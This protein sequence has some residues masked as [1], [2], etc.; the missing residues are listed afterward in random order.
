MKKLLH[1]LGFLALAT[2]LAACAPAPTSA[3]GNFPNSGNNNNGT[4][5]TTNTNPDNTNPDNNPDGGTVNTM[6]SNPLNNGATYSGV[7]QSNATL[8]FTQPGVLPGL[9]S[10]ALAAL[11][12]LSTDPG[13][14]LVNFAQAAG[15]VHLDSTMRGVISSVITNKL[16]NVLP[17]NVKQALDLISD[18]TKITQTTTLQNTITV[19]TP[20]STGS[21]YVDVVV[22]G[23]A[24]DFVDLNLNPQHV[25]VKTSSA[26]LAQSKS[27][28]LG[29]LTPHPNAPVAD[30]DLTFTGGSIS[31]PIGDFINQAMGP[32][33]FKPMWGTTDLK[34]T[35]L[36]LM[37][38]PCTDLGYIVQSGVYD[39]TTLD[40]GN[41]VGT[42]IC[43]TAVT[44]A[45]NEI[46][47]EI[48]KLK[49]N[50]VKI[51]DGRATLTDVSS[52]KPTAD[53]KSDLLDGGSWTWTFGGADV[54][55]SIDD[56]TRIATAI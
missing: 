37:Q 13:S 18:I 36:Y 39:L 5:G 42:T 56:G 4:G 30:A 11:A 33:L 54:P 10:P 26:Y 40:I 21:V 38:S 45:A 41:D 46:V 7:Y 17:D 8:D 22:T 14:A 44:L 23:A 43:T 20:S 35:L 25:V 2:T 29:T 3:G 31:I 34:S 47:S 52:K 27:T 9:V 55:A 16:N 6:P 24:F 48:G 12:D 19:H 50:N 28:I 32:L 51:T 49:V 15:A 1:I 53:H